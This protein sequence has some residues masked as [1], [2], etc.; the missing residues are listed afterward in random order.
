VA[1]Q[2]TRGNRSM[3]GP[4]ADDPIVVPS[5]RLCHCQSAAASA[6]LSIPVS[7]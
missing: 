7:A 1:E 4:A 5:N 6:A 3:T 2:G